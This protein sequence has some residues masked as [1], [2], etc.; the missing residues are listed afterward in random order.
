MP[1]IADAFLNTRA[2]NL[3][4]DLFDKFIVPPFFQ[5]ISIFEDKR[6]VRILGGRGCG[7]TMFIRYFCHG[8]TFSVNKDNIPDT[9]LAGI[10][11]YF[12]PDTG[13]CALMSPG[14]LG[15]HDARL[16]FSHYVALS[17]LLEA[18]RAL[19]SLENAKLAN[20]P[21]PLANGD[22]GRSLV[23][24]LVLQTPTISAL[25]ERVNDL[26]DELELWVRN[27]KQHPKPTFL[28]FA[29]MIPKLAQ[30]LSTW[31]PRME[32]IAFR[33]FI[34]EFEN[35]Q[36]SHREIICDAIKHPHERLR[37]HIAHKR[38]AVTD[39][40]TSSDERI[41]LLHDLRVIDLEEELSKGTD[42]ELLA[43]ELFLLRLHE[44]K[45][46]FNCPAFFPKK[47][48]DPVHLEYRLSSE[49]RKE[50]T[51]CVRQILPTLTSKEISQAVI[52]DAPLR[53]R[54]GEYIQKGLQLQKAEDRYKANDLI[55][56]TRP[57]ASIVLG[58]LLN[59]KTQKADDVI[60]QFKA[61]HASDC[62]DSVDP[63]FKTGGWVDNNL[64]GCLFHLFA[65][66]P[67]RPNILYAGFER[68][69][70]LASPNLRFFQELCHTALLLAFNRQHANKI[71][72][73]LRVDHDKQALAAKQV[74]DALFHDIL[75]L[76]SHGTRLL[77]IANR[78]G[79][80][81]EA[82]N[83]RR[84]Q[85]ETEI[86]HFSI[87]QADRKDL[88]EASQILLREAKVWSVLYEE[89]DTKGKSNHDISQSDLVLNRIYSPHF[90][91]SY[92]KRKK[93]T[94][95]AGE[96][97]VIFSQSSAQFEM[98]LKKLVEPDDDARPH[99]TNSLF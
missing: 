34:D 16:A 39:F 99:T 57:E 24:L 44:A 72:G 96:V 73:Q 98:L 92:R 23:N 38:D 11:L 12:R 7:K 41:V 26:L 62:D 40:K 74:S 8:T 91:I 48:H 25:E 36:P 31:S 22:L 28:S 5:R 69:C 15:E 10:G 32:G 95:R 97:D 49:Y 83:R 30:N 68:Y 58:A 3:P 6:S 45:V 81:F 59:R 76:G 50:V 35:L 71:E 33:T 80:V 93:I 85:S 94:L 47:L 17:L 27:P 65:G 70:F 54:L 37:V 55:S 86:N 46:E 87:D 79:R 67:R 66:L 2:D 88:S 64:Y 19:E 61:S 53:R 84:S 51:S 63:F 29:S 89:K 4:N 43:A 18:S 52:N 60:A 82:F 13:F 14:W 90:S 78:L 56:D 21:L 20:G 77:E 75:E 9:E 1:V 42:F